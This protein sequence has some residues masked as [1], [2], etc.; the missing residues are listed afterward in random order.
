MAKVNGSHEKFEKLGASLVEQRAKLK[1]LEAQAARVR[2]K[3]QETS[4]EMA[5]VETAHN[6]AHQRET[7]LKSEIASHEAELAK[8]K[9]IRSLEAQAQDL[10]KKAE[11]LRKKAEE[12][13]K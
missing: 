8:R 2:E 10:L 7:S 3:V 11:V 13:K 6:E 1:D 12:L 4:R 5:G 9:E